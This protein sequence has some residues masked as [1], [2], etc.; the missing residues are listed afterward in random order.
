MPPVVIAY[1]GLEQPMANWAK[2]VKYHSGMVEDGLACRVLS[3]DHSLLPIGP[4][5]TGIIGVLYPRELETSKLATN[6]ILISKLGTARVLCLPTRP[7]QPSS[8]ALIVI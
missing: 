6:R 3:G 1:G 2:R 8:C 7:P 4:G 5:A